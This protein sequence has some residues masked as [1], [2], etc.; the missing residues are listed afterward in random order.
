MRR[1]ATGSTVKIEEM[2]EWSPVDDQLAYTRIDGEADELFVI[3]ASDGTRTSLATGNIAPPYPRRW[4]R[5]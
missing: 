1:L 4:R 2:W 5:R 3:D